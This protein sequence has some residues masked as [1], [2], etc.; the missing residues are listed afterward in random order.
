VLDAL[1]EEGSVTGAAKRMKVSQPTVSFSLAKLRIY[2]RDD[3]FTRTAGRMQP[4]PFALTL[5]PAVQEVM[6]IVQ[7]DVVPKAHFSPA[8][9]TRTF[10]VCTSDVGELCFLPLLIETFETRAPQ[11]SLRCLSLPMSEVKG[12]M[13]AG[14]IDLA[15][16]YFPDLSSEE[17]GSQHLFDH[18]FVCIARQDHPLVSA[19]LTLENYMDCTHAVVRHEGRSQEI[20][21]KAI[22]C[23]DANRRV[24]L[25]SQHFVSLPFLIAKSD[26]VSI[27][28][29]SL[30]T[31]FAQVVGLQSVKPPIDIP[32]IPLRQYWANRAAT[33]PAIAWLVALVE[34]LFQ[35]RDPT[36]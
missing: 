5:R 30:A 3:L 10:T 13:I 32:D 22:E 33:D 28:P 20:A 23:M 11:A 31:S 34:E 15:L 17:I 6:T 29:R 25:Q 16:G 2:F 19:H 14:N 12:A 9:T 27:V 1:Y 8:D 7:R 24:M 21:E 26:L 36:L 35:D 4:T 18:P